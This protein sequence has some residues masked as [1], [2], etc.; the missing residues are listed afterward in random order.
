M[1]LL[2]AVVEGGM[3]AAKG[4]RERRSPPHTRTHPSLAPS[5]S[6]SKQPPL[7]SRCSS[8][9]DRHSF[10]AATTTQCAANC[11]LH[12][13]LSICRLFTPFDLLCFLLNGGGCA[14]ICF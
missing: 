9:D 5:V 2:V 13:S 12:L 1:L 8:N 4:Q 11:V 7:G 14:A 10:T 6:G 3:G